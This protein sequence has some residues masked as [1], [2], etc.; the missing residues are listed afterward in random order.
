MR[1]LAVSDSL[2]LRRPTLAAGLGAR[3]VGFVFLLLPAVAS[4]Q[5]LQKAAV[6]VDPG[7]TK[8]AGASFGYR[9][10]YNCS[11]TSGPCLGATVED[12][13][14][15]EVQEVST[16]P[17]SP[18]GDVAAVAVTPNY[19]GSGRTRVVFTMISPLPAGNSGDLII[20]VRFPN[21][22]TPDG[23]SAINTADGINLQTSPGT[24]TTPPVTVTSVATPQVTLT[25]AL[26]T[27][28][29]NLDL[30]ET[31]RLRI[32]VPASNGALNLTA[33][34]PVVDTLPPGTVFTG[35]TPAADCEPGCVGTAPAT[36]TWTSPC[37]LPI[38]PG[39]QCDVLVNVVF[40][41]A[42]FPSGTN[43]TNSF[44]ADATPL[45]EPG[46]GF[47]PGTI[48]HPVTT[49]VPNPSAGL[50]KGFF[51]QPQ[52]PALDMDFAWS[53]GVSNNGNVA[54]DSYEM[55][56]TLPVEVSVSSVTTGGYSTPP[57]TV[58][59]SYEKNTA[60][61]VF[62]LWGSSPGA[63]N[64]TLTAPPPGLGAG[65]YLTRIRWQYGTVQPGFSGSA[66]LNVHLL[67]VD[68]LGAPVNVG[69]TIQNCADLTAVYAA[70][71]TN[72]SRNT[73]HSF[74]VS[75][76]FAR[77]SPAKTNLSGAGPFGV[78]ALIS[79]QLSA[80]NENYGAGSSNITNPV[81]VDLLPVDLVYQSGTATCLNATCL[82]L[83]P[84]FEEL[85]NYD[86]TGRTLLRWS[87]VGD[88]LP[89]T[90][91]RVGF[92]T[93]V[94]LG[95][96]F[97]TLQNTM[98]QT[99]SPGGVS[100]RCSSSAT[101]INDLD[102]DGSRA[103]T[104]C[105]AS[106]NATIA[107][108][109]QLVSTKQ[110]QGTCDAGFTAGSAGSLPGGSFNYRLQVSNAGTVPMQNF[111]MID[112]LA[113]VG[114]TGVLDTSPRGSQW[115]PLLTAPITPP[116][117]TV[118]YYSTAGN[119][120]R[121]EVGGITSGCDAPNWTTVPPT[122]ITSARSFKIEFGGRVVNPADALTIVFPMTAPASLPGG[123]L[124]SFNSFAYL[125]ARADGLGNLAAEPLKVGMT[126]GNCTAAALG[127]YVWIDANGN[128]N[129][130][131]PAT[132]GLNGVYTQLFSPGLDGIAG[133]L[134]DALIATTLTAADGGGNPGYYQ[135]PG[136]AA[137]TYYVCFERPPNYAVSPLNA[138]GDALDSDVD[139]AT[140]CTAPVTLGV[141]ES[142]QTVDLGLVPLVRAA[143]GNYA[144]FDTNGDG[145]QNEPLEQGV[146][147]VT[148]KLFAD[149]GNGIAE[150]GGADGLPVAVTV[151]TNDIYG[152][153][154][155][156]RFEELIPGLGY[157]VQ[158]MLP[159]SASG[160]TVR[161]AGGDDSVDSDASPSN[162]TSQIVVLG[163]GEYN[164]TVDAGLVRPGGSLR[165]GN[166][167][168]MDNDNDGAYEPEL[169]EMGVDGVRL[170][171]YRDAN[172]D[173]VP[174][175]D[176]YLTTTTTQTTSGF[177][178]RYLFSGLTAGNYIVVVDAGNF[179]GSGPL[180]GK[181]SST[182]N[183]PAPD[184]DDDVNGDDNG[185][186]AGA[187]LV[188]RPITLSA[189]G[190]PTADGDDNNTNSTLDFGFALAAAAPQFDYGDDPDAT[191][192]TAAGDYRTTALDAGA[193]H[194]LGG[195]AAP[196]LGS[197]VDADPGTLQGPAA[198]RDDAAAFGL[199]VGN[200]AAPGDDED[201]VSFSNPLIPGGSTTITVAAASGTGA[202]VLNAWIDWNG[203]GVFGDA[204]G[205]QI[206]GDL[207][208]AS[209]GVAN[210]TPTV[211][212]NAR[213]GRTYARFRCSSASGLGP[214]GPA[215]DGEVEDYLVTVTG[216]DLGDAPD[217][218]AT[219][220]AANGARH[221]VDPATSLF[222]GSCVD[223]EADGQPSGT[224]TG[225][226]AVQGTSVVGLCFDDEE[227]ISFG[228]PPVACTT[229][230][231]SV[232]ANAAG[233]LDAWIDFNANGSFA[234]V[235]ERIASGQAVSAGANLLTFSVP[236]NASPTLTY[237]RFRL[238]S[239]GVA[240]FDGPAAD[241]EVE[242][243]QV[244]VK[245]NDWGDAPAPY[246]TTLAAGGAFH[247]VDP[248]VP[249]FLGGCVDTE[250]DGQGT[251]AADGDDL[252]NGT[253]V[254]GTCSAND[255]EDGITFT[256][257]VVACQ[258]ATLTVSA[259]LAGVLDAWVDLNRNGSWGDPGEHVLA[260]QAVAGG[261]NALAFGVP[262]DAG[263]GLTYARFRYGSASSPLPTGAAADGEIEDYA[264][265]VTALDLGDA[266][267][268]Y[269]TTLGAGGPRH[270][271]AAGS[272]LVLGSCVDDEADGVP[273]A[274][275]SGDDVAVG[276]PVAG[277]CSGNDDE[278]GVTFTS[279]VNACQTATLTVVAGAPGLLDAFL[280]FNRN[281]SFADAGEKIFADWPL[282]AG[283]NA[284]TF[285]VPCDAAEGDTYARFRLSSAG[286]L[287]ATG[288]AADGEVEDYLLTSNGADFGDAP[289]GYG[290]TLAAG[291]P[292]HGVVA[293]SPLYLGSCVDTE[294]DAATPL[295]ASGD[296]VTP[297][298]Q[299][300]GACNGNDDEDGV[301]FDT[302]LVACQ[303]AQLTVTTVGGGALD[304]W[305][306]F[307][308]DGSFATAGDRIATAQLLANGA[309]TLSV[310]V[311]CGAVA[312]TTYARFRLSSAGGLG[313]GG[314]AVDGEV[315]DYAVAVR[316]VDFG[317]APDSY[318]TTL[319]A[320]GAN[321]GIVTGFSLGATIDGELD[322]QPSTGANGDGADE[323]GVTFPGT[324]PMVTAC[325]PTSLTITLTNAAGIT[326]P[327]LDA[328]I[329]FDGD[330]TFG[331]PRDRIATALPLVAGANTLTFTPPCD[332]RSV[333]SYARF[334]LSS[335]SVPAA[336]GP[337]DDGEVEDYAVTVKGLDFGDAPGPTYP[338]L[339]ASNGARHAVLPAGNPT[340]GSVVDTEADGQPSA[341]H[342]G[343]DTNG[344]P[345]DEDGVAFP[346]VLIPG[347][348]GSVQI[349][350]G[351]AGGNLSAW[352][353]FNND[354]DW[355][356]TGEQVLAD[357]AVGAGA[358]VT[359]G[360]PVPV[361]ALAGTACARFRLST[362]TGL[363]V[364]G[365]AVDGEVED[366]LAPVGVEQPSVGVTKQLAGTVNEGGGV[367]LLTFEVGLFNLGN[368]PLTNVNATADFATAFADAAGFEVV[369]VTSPD[370]TPNPTFDGGADILLLAAGNGL[371]VGESGVISV[372]VRVSTGGY[373]GPYTCSSL[374]SGTSPA[375][376]EVTD[377]SQ[378]GTDPDSNGNGD[379]TDD[380]TPTIF[381][382]DIGVLSI[383]TLSG[384]GLGLLTALLSL[385]ALAGLRRRA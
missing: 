328:W 304:A 26:T 105:A 305:I 320:G 321:H 313:S 236:C 57:A 45:G 365:L 350:T 252:G 94:R 299:T 42:S 274:A 109:A 300:V 47:G 253:S 114:D 84:T 188:S 177:A 65:E 293:A 74:A 24:F 111:V 307:A 384:L 337:G 219:T 317:D 362:Q 376:M 92:D 216:L 175:L 149:N 303:I 270:A 349:T 275:A 244:R 3:L 13:L 170:D 306:D 168:W 173:G 4:A 240:S 265:T 271:L 372:Q 229:A 363:G 29:A 1:T 286:G 351:T 335:T 368:V 51:G 359:L 128:G 15:P 214:D 53:V 89:G 332:A 143:L 261:A 112:I 62:T 90:D 213:P 80:N 316:A 12:L 319:A 202:C 338:V 144:F 91:L 30:P 364:T 327:L 120:C 380:N 43:V 101:D 231:V 155:Y 311:P 345:D 129:Q 278:D 85:P 197:C 183:D 383:P 172:A 193:A 285:N 124:A 263:L 126:L 59:V 341:S 361:G 211:P 259:N 86:G 164:P 382:L 44:V 138:I 348:T 66:R 116:P 139:P 203:S 60:P 163:A 354:G 201:G 167:V 58:T 302:P 224:A 272:Q 343:D 370:F 217:T 171:L 196:Y 226:D 99:F 206:A 102:G 225:D 377:V 289:D 68:N 356:D 16:V 160:F 162:G 130:D 70:G 277:T 366:H 360:F 135:F 367:F 159:S 276:F 78:N 134:D 18:T 330:G 50:S 151:T 238:S 142:N 161:N 82:S 137:G 290:T 230:Q 334:R 248:A 358:A 218:Y 146:N 215:I 329:D 103:D 6:Q 21:G 153:P 210:L 98:G 25:K 178:G 132:A 107:P 294:N 212:A 56:D 108:I 322:G 245:G 239:T 75:G 340:L 254:V 192:G 228:T 326:V 189:G 174:T 38:T 106:G 292:N 125:G 347:T 2:P 222:L 264:L 157:F 79:W 123:G 282:A 279:Q 122:P 371:G 318:G 242:D 344:S 310:N 39:G 266:P 48:T 61:G 96:T 246:P 83:S 352:I 140:G 342:N 325:E 381:T 227:G 93:R 250:V 209:G 199:T 184:P 180:A 10:T 81:I 52:P 118:L 117:G 234:D 233:L 249:R 110:V 27:S 7:N 87:F 251:A 223:T 331:T 150:P 156:Y 185:T 308:A 237:A 22:S 323:D 127:D 32:A 9:L 288:A 194:Q 19:M 284:L 46:Q 378:D 63:S 260:A 187:L 269:G 241:G 100:Q 339:L 273:S 20:N 309:N 169:G 355:N 346:A 54:L 281:G 296:D 255:D 36:L 287:G 283:A 34:G 76:P 301:S 280:D 267:D 72:V 158:F 181:Q 97:G 31:Y 166:Q 208:I 28:P 295:D 147:G 369:G 148:V 204:P 33:V 35:A 73:C 235:G 115:T 357:V 136:L 198:D 333:A 247:A 336:T 88:L 5:P 95:A 243:S 40:P 17:A 268:S 67:G 221:T 104:L 298:D 195:P 41:S 258:T 324:M 353:D 186:S 152:A 232:S 11:S 131:E 297:G 315:E 374:G 55:I 205:E 190:E 49:F 154:G 165:L 64:S 14:P 256:S 37:A 375:G 182:G 113:F 191:T 8:Q 176:E 257:A 121:P 314:A 133:T 77:S 71:P 119:P 385:A 262:C 312:G 207:T 141:G 373:P 145:I 220:L 379:P 200:C 179:S 69:D 23:T 291:G